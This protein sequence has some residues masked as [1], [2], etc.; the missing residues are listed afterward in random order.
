MQL[1]RDSAWAIDLQH[2]VFLQEGRTNVPGSKGNAFAALEL[3]A[4]IAALLAAF[5]RGGQLFRRETPSLL[6]P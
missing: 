1:A 4:R 2:C 5:K 6:R 3:S